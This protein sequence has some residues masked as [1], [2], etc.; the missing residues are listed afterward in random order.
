M[1]LDSNP[2]FA[3]VRDEALRGETSGGRAQRVRCGVVD[4]KADVR[5]PGPG[6]GQ[7]E[8]FWPGVEPGTEAWR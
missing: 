1:V 7:P 3:G 4:S 2:W 6:I 8:V 5:V